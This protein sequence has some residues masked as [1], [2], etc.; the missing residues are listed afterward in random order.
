MVLKMLLQ[1]YIEPRKGSILHFNVNI[2]YEMRL[3]VYWHSSWA[4]Q[5]S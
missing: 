1:A 2:T 4:E 5:T 3:E